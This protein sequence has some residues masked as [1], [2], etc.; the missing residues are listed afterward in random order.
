MK[1][2]V[3][4]KKKLFQ[5]SLFSFE[6]ANLKVDSFKGGQ[7][8]ISRY[9]IKT[10]E[11]VAALLYLKDTKKIVLVEQF[12]YSAISKT[13]GWVLEVI[14]GLVEKNESNE[15]SLKREILEESGYEIDRFE[16]IASYFPNV[17]ITNQFLHFYFA[18]SC[19]YRK[20]KLGGGLLQEKEDI[21]VHELSLEDIE[22]KY[23]KQE[24]IDSKTIIALQWFLLNKK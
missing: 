22:L 18:E 4:N 24:F 8:N 6:E 3:L 11:V 7:E 21:R 9:E 15:E 10:P 13:S 19:S 14:A 1:Y 23:H 17:G 16:K 5:K 12:R 2:E 20:T